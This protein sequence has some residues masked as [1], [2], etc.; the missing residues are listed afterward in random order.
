MTS[1]DKLIWSAT[2]T[3][4]LADGALDAASVERLVEHH[5]AM[6]V[7][8]LFLAGSCGEGPLMPNAQRAELTRLV[9]RLA[10][11]RLQLAV[12][13][14][15]T[16]AA[17]VVENIR[18]AED[19]GADAVVIA[20]PWL[21]RF[22]N[23]DFARR[24]FGE[25][26]AAAT[27]PVGLYVL[28]QPP[29]TGLDLALWSEFATHP[30]VRLLK[31][32]SASEANEAAFAAVRRQRKDLMLLTGY[33]F[34]VIRAIEAGYDG[35]LLGTGIL[36]AG[37]IRRALDALASGDRAAADA[38]QTRAN[39]FMYDLFGKDIGIWL[40]GLK[41]ALVRL[42]IFSTAQLHLCYTISDA[43]RARIDAA[44]EREAAYLRPQGR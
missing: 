1:S 26:I 15:D 21:P 27:A 19:A 25:A 3:P 43:E 24:Y 16:S 36:V 17:R 31:D 11:A 28:N 41:Y 38:W 8:G 37:F 32:S 20:P 9:K 40:G 33:E 6:G 10:G 13:V 29:E 2:P 5:V 12:Q 7:K 34:N 44:L 22:C 35:G 18:Q 39:T 23:R 14:S 30:K 4:F 42:G